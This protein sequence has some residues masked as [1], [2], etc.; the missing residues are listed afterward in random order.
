M[1]KKRAR[2]TQTGRAKLVA[3]VGLTLDGERLPTKRK[4]RIKNAPGLQK[5]GACDW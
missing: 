1:N 4:V 5:P 3:G 2:F